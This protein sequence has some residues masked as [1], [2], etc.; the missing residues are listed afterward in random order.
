MHPAEHRSVDDNAARIGFMRGILVILTA[1]AI[2]AFVVAQGLDDN[3]LEPVAA[4]NTTVDS[5]LEGS[6]DAAGDG[7]SAGAGLS[8]TTVAGGDDT[9]AST[10]DT[11][12]VDPTTTET[13][14]TTTPPEPTLREPAEVAVLVLNGAGTKGIAGQGAEVMNDAGYQ[15]L[16]PKNAN[17]LGPSQVLYIEG[18]EAEARVVAES[19]GVDPA[20]VLSPYDPGSPPI[21]EI[22][23]ANVIVIIGQDGLIEP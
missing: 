8:T 4:E 21:D 13:T 22:R 16:A 20:S 17:S 14:V 1:V 11:V 6:A 5:S 12:A 19:F 15:V 9:A 7:S 23:E 2:G 18:F 10:T 3:T